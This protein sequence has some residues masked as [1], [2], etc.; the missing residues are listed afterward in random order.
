M[1]LSHII[2]KDY[3]D[4]TLAVLGGTVLATD[5]LVFEDSV[6]DGYSTKLGVFY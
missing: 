3:Y 4:P 6:I 1:H 5:A 2:T